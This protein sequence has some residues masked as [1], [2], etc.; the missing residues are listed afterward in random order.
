MKPLC[1]PDIKKLDDEALDFKNSKMR[2]RLFNLAAVD[3][4]V[5]SGS[6]ILGL[7]SKSRTMNWI[8]SSVFKHDFINKGNTKGIATADSIETMLAISEANTVR[9]MDDVRGIYAEYMGVSGKTFRDERSLLASFDKTKLDITPFSREI[10]KAMRRGDVH[11]IPAVQK[12]AKRLRKEVDSAMLGL[13]EIGAMAPGTS[14]KGA[15]SWLMRKYLRAEMVS[16]EGEKKLKAILDRN[17]QDAHPDPVTRLKE[18]NK[19][20]KN[21]QGIGDDA[22]EMDGF[23]KDFL[24]NG[25]NPKFLKERTLNIPDEELM[26][27][28]DHDVLNVVHSFTRQANAMVATHKQLQKMGVKNIGELKKMIVDDYDEL[29]A[30]AKNNKERLKLTKNRDN[31]LRR[32]D[33]FFEIIN[34][35]HGTDHPFARTLRK[36]NASTMLGSVLISSI[37]DVA[38]QVYKNGMKSTLKELE[39]T[40][41]DWKHVSATNKELG[42]L[43]FAIDEMMNSTIKAITDPDYMKGAFSTNSFERA[44]DRISG[45][46]AKLTL[47]GPWN[48]GLSR[49]GARAQLGALSDFMEDIKLGKASSKDIEEFASR[50]IGV[51]Q[52]KVI[53]RNMK[54]FNDVNGTKIPDLSRWDDEGLKLVRSMVH[55]GDTI[56][57]PGAGQ[58]PEFF[59]RNAF[60][61]LVFQ[62]KSFLVAAHN[63]ILMKGLQRMD[64]DRAIAFAMLPALGALSMIIKNKLAGRDTNM[65]LDNLIRE[66]FLRSGSFGLLGEAIGLTVPSLQSSKYAGLNAFGFFGG[67]SL[68]R[69]AKLNEAIAGLQ[70]GSGMSDEDAKKFLK[71]IPPLNLFYL[72][73]LYE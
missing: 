50:G 67:P 19:T 40:L 3:N 72:R 4:E 53:Q 12:S 42:S 29:I 28:F 36:W 44:V 22:L 46:F 11:D 41:T 17:F 24:A 56:L 61:K 26:D 48:T 9:A 43:N 71:F 13:V 66:G 8:T 27:F 34:G 52:Y 14:V 65:D 39:R 47:L 31:D 64:A 18:V 21:M 73:A 62:F 5:V 23:V 57:K 49:F 51:A 35:V 20:Y 7:T 37:P 59:L 54:F 68:S 32:T 38:V 69:A 45:A 30:A 2:E 58:I 60:T 1:P 55:R 33:T 70:D 63:D 16:R 25:P 15:I 6:T 10:G